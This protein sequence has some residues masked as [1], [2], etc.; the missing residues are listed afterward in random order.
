[1]NLKDAMAVHLANSDDT[2]Q[3]IAERI[4]FKS[5]QTL[6]SKLDGT[7][8]I[9]LNEAVEFSKIL[10]VGIDEICNMALMK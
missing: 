4:G 8:E 3:S 1:M 10:G 2:K 7:S 5:V 9:S 6:N